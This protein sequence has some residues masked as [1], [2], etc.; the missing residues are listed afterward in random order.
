MATLT[1]TLRFRFHRQQFRCFV[2]ARSV[3]CRYVTWDAF[4]VIIRAVYRPN[5]TCLDQLHN[6]YWV[7]GTTVA[8]ETICIYWLQ[9]SNFLVN[10]AVWMSFKLFPKSAE[11][12]RQRQMDQIR[13][14]PH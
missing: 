5:N 1:V 10:Y 11:F 12:H 8:I 6:P 2:V 3:F 9:Q 14:L 4:T 7:T 13:L